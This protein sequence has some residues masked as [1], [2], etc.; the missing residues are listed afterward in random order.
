M[1]DDYDRHW[2]RQMPTTDDS[3]RRRR[4]ALDYQKED[5]LIL[6]KTKKT[7]KSRSLMRAT[8]SNPSDLRFISSPQAALRNGTK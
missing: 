6:R 5:L 8:D 3:W 2:Y 7:A 4:V 1:N